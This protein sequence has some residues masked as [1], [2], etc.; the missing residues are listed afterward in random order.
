MSAPATTAPLPDAA[1][2]FGCASSAVAFLTGVLGPGLSIETHPGTF[3]L[4][5]LKRFVVAA[6]AV[7]VAVV[8]LGAPAIRN[9]GRVALPVKVS[10][11]ILTKP[12]P[13]LSAYQAANALAT[14]VIVAVSNDVVGVGNG[15][16]V[17][18]VR[19]QNDYSGR[20]EEVGG[21]IALWQV[22]WTQSIVLGA[23][24]FHAEDVAAMGDAFA[25]S[26]ARIARELAALVVQG[27]DAPAGGRTYA[28]EPGAAHRPDG[29]AGLE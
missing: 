29:E 2:S 16:P 17:T 5:A 13:P 26:T 22:T 11:A 6:P 18:D 10:A 3:D 4:A 1:D 25:G 7:R 14:A 24:P 9:D 21:E 12:H 27:T 19:A 8:G 20:L 15:Y 23:D 28:P